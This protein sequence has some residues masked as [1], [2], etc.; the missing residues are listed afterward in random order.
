LSKD[1]IDA[2]MPAEGLRFFN[3]SECRRAPKLM[4]RVVMAVESLPA[5]S[6][7]ST[8]T[9]R[10]AAAGDGWSFADVIGRAAGN[11]PSKSK[12]E[13]LSNTIAEN[14]NRAAQ[15]SKL[16]KFLSTHRGSPLY[17]KLLLLCAAHAMRR[18]TIGASLKR[19]AP[20]PS[21]V[22]ATFEHNLKF[23]EEEAS[24]NRIFSEEVHKVLAKT[25]NSDLA[26]K[27]AQ[28]INW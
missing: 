7:I 4:E 14:E 19:G 9:R 12:T 10:I 20:D 11:L 6:R 27:V 15:V 3:L 21:D 24:T 22:K 28:I 16:R 17:S 26:P 23:A 8:D 13:A 25:P 18:K 5:G 1:R 2:A